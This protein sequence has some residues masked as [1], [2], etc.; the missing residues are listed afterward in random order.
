MPGMEA[1]GVRPAR[2]YRAAEGERL[3]RF[4]TGGPIRLAADGALLATACAEDVKVVEYATGAVQRTLPGDSEPITALA[5]T[6]DGQHVFTS[7]RSLVSK[8]WSLRTG[9]AL[10]SWKS[11]SAP[12]W[13]MKVDATGGLLAT[14]SADRTL[15]VWDADKGFCT[16]VFRGHRDIVLT[17]AFNHDRHRLQLYSGGV[18]AEEH[19][20]AVTS[21]SLSPCGWL[22]LS[23]GRDKMVMVWDLRTHKKVGGVPVLEAVEGVVA[24]PEDMDFPGLPAARSPA[25]IALRKAKGVYFCTVGE[26]GAVR[27]WNSKTGAA[28]HTTATC[29]EAA[30]GPGENGAQ[31]SASQQLTSVALLPRVLGC[32]LLVCNGDARMMVFSPSITK[33]SETANKGTLEMSKQLIGNNDEVT[34]LRLLSLGGAGGDAT[35]VALASN[36]EAVRVFS[37]ADRSCTASLE[38]HTETVLCLDAAQPPGGGCVLLASGSKDNSVR[39]WGADP[40]RPL[41]AGRGHIGAVSAVAFG[42]CG[43]GATGRV[44]VSGGADKLVKVWDISPFVGAALPAAQVALA[45]L[46]ATAAVAAH[47]K[48][49]NAVALSPDDNLLVTASA[50]RTARLWR[51]PNLLPLLTLKGHKRGVWAAAFSPVDKVVATASGDRTI[52][53][54]TISDGSCLK[55]FEGHTASVLRCCFLNAGT[56]LMSSGADGLLKLWSVRSTECVNTFDEHEDRVWALTKAPGNDALLASGGSDAIVNIWRDCTASD[57]A[58]EEKALQENLLRTQDLE[59]ALMYEEYEEAAKLAFQLGHPGKLLKVV[60]AILDE[61]AAPAEG[62]EEASWHAQL[63]RLVAA[64]TAEEIK[65]ALEYCQEW[66]TKARTCIPA[67]AMVG[68][69]LANHPRDAL[70]KV[71]GLGELLEGLTAYSGRHFRRLTQL[72]RSTFLLDYMLS[73][74]NSVL[75]DGQ[76]LESDDDGAPAWQMAMLQA[77]APR[78]SVGAAAGGPSGDALDD[79]FEGLEEGGED[80][81]EEEEEEESDGV[82]TSGGLPGWGGPGLI[83]EEAEEEEEGSEDSEEEE[84]EEE[85]EVEPA[86]SL[87]K[88]GRK[89]AASATPKSKVAVKEENNDDDDEDESEEDAEGESEEEEEE[90]RKEEIAPPRSLSKKGKKAAIQATPKVERKAAKVKATPKS[91]GRKGS[92]RLPETPEATP[93]AGGLQSGKRRRSTGGEVTPAPGKGTKTPRAKGAATALKSRKKSKAY[94]LERLS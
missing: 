37:M 52:K 34:D 74:M 10:H 18:D 20:S 30:A 32:G 6:P 90:E 48:D 41:A 21:L 86:N 33:V 70:M 15:R 76:G 72:M 81:E 51:M 66:N 61:A 75:P 29:A 84:Q 58:E 14:A 8:K 69:I 2:T 28:V 1:G 42:S 87:R 59:N 93:K 57:A 19:Y 16:H 27:L 49:I 35:H 60:N 54:W 44:L 68:A 83:E 63:G 92:E 77:P 22:L 56:Q 64:F 26:K 3:Q 82:E 43:A 85:E 88:Q 78:I 62:G 80:M 73:S 12:V 40:W 89:E 17:C 31:E 71:P 9:E 91:A 24:L 65:K 55:T 45:S 25:W 94:I 53:L 5:I 4:F 36:T 38:G 67:Q 47:D 13:D 39:L 79:D 50:D 11:H 46:R 23:G 7:S